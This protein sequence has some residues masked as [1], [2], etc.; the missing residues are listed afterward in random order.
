MPR[1]TAIAR[2]LPVLGLLLAKPL[3]AAPP[4]PDHIVIVIEEN[5]ALAQVIGSPDAPYI[6][7]LANGRGGAL[8]TSFYAVTHPSQP[9]YLHFFSGSNQGVT[10]DSVPTGTP[11]T[12]ANLGAALLAAGRTFAGYSEDL[13]AVGSQ[14][15][16]YFAY[17]RKHNPWA[18]WQATAPAANQLL[19]SVNRPFFSRGADPQ[20]FYGD[21]GYPIDFNLL[22][23]VA[24]VVPNLNNDMH[25]GTIAQADAWLQAHIAPY[26]DW[27]MAHNSLL[28]IT[29]DEDNSA[30]RDHIPTIFHGP[31]IH[32]G[33]NAV[34]Y[35]LH[36]LL[37]TIEDMSGSGASG[38]AANVRP[39]VGSFNSDIAISTRRFQQGVAGYAG[40]HD[41]YLQSANPDTA[42]GS[43]TPLVADGSPLTQALIRFDNI[44]GY[45]AA[46]VPAG[47]TILSAKLL[48]LTGPSS[49][50]SDSSAN[51][52]ALHRM[53]VGWNDLST[54]NSLT[55]GVSADGVEAVA[56]AEF[57]LIPNV[58]DAW[59]I[60]DATSSVQAWVS[61]QAANFGWVVLPS[62]TDGWRS[63]SSEFA[64]IAD[65]PI[66]E[67]TFRTPCAG[68]ANGDW[69][70]NVD[71][72]L[73]VITS[74]GGA[75]GAAD[76]NH[77]GVV[78]V[79]DLLAVITSWGAC[80]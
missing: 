21:L 39:I 64:T 33:P 2:V 60:F 3:L 5:H 74:W 23:S 52:M 48:M 57:S 20:P 10:N 18:N 37:R 75:G 67:V 35:T 77:D 59:A 27:A 68:D 1:P 26:A 25:D 54:W 45:G 40:A 43:L 78:N 56:A 69:T 12:T 24:I 70:V 38:S 51:V 76:V 4:A 53:L 73:A 9:N 29:W 49:A 7:S 58:L 46:Q 44:I 71:D 65:R 79:D 22:P 32:P 16:T 62:G 50:S 63:D 66:L 6:N 11:F 61:G 8:F 13:P 28:V 42:A 55:G 36:N 41:T 19:P 80:P 31:M 14:V 34:T 72:L 15:A 47:A 30:S 17:A